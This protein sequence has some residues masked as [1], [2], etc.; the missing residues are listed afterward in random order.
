[1][2]FDRANFRYVTRGDLDYSAAL[3]LVDSRKCSYVLITHVLEH[4]KYEEAL[5]VKP[6]DVYLYSTYPLSY[7]HQYMLVNNIVE[8][9]DRAA[10]KYLDPEK[11]S[12]GFLSTWCS[13][14]IVRYLAKRWKLVDVSDIF[15]YSRLVKEAD[16]IESIKKAGSIL[17]RSVHQALSELRAGITELDL[18]SLIVS[19]II[20]LEGRPGVFPIIASGTR[21]AIH[22]AK[23]SNKK[24]EINELVVIEIVVE[25]EGYNADATFTYAMPK[26]KKELR[27]VAKIVEEAQLNTKNMVRTGIRARDLDSIARKYIEMKGYGKY[28]IHPTGHGIGLEI[29]EPPYIAPETDTVLE[30][31][32]I[33]TVEPGIHILGLGGAKIGDTVLVTRKGYEELTPCLKLKGV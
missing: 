28:F 32:M 16:E 11:D 29:H 3:L 18:A 5:K 20:R 7:D 21:S 13:D 12:V 10:T 8:A 15:T 25:Y 17:C 24:I 4:A 19:E 26:V 27:D 23:A 30:E 1:M 33:L 2:I 22:N 9:V 6:Q 31:G 14:G